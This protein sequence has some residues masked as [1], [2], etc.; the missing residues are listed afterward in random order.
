[1]APLDQR[2]NH[3]SR[4]Q[5]QHS[6]DQGCTQP[7]PRFHQTHTESEQCPSEGVRQFKEGK[8]HRPVGWAGVL[9]QHAAVRGERILLNVQVTATMLIGMPKPPTSANAKPAPIVG[10]LISDRSSI[11]CFYTYQDISSGFFKC[12]S[13]LLDDRVDFTSDVAFEATDDIAPA[14][15]FRGSSAQVRLRPQVVAQPDDDY[16]I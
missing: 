16:A 15:S 10:A 5:H 11:R 1:M 4:N 8:Q 6:G 9:V 14:H 12:L 7:K 2:V 3:L 13:G